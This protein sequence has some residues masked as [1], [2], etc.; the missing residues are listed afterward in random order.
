MTEMIPMQTEF[1]PVLPVVLN[2]VDYAIFRETLLRM[3]EIIVSGELD[4]VVMAYAVS[5]AERE[6]MALAAEKG[7]ALAGLS[8][9]DVIRIQKAGEQALRCSVARHLTGEAYRPFSNRL[10]DSPLLQ[11][12][13]LIDRLD[14]I[15]VPTK[16][17]LQRFEKMVPESMIREIVNK[18]TLLG[19]SGVSPTM[20]HVMGLEDPL[21]LD[22]LYLD[23]TAVKMNIHYPVD[24]VLLRDATRTLMKAVK[25]IRE[26]GLRNRMQEPAEFI[27]G[28]NRLCIEMTQAARKKE[29]KRNRKRIFR[30]M[31]KLVKKVR[32]HAE[33]HLALL[34]EHGDETDLSQ[35]R[36]LAIEKRI[37]GI[38]QKL[39]AAVHQ[40]HERIIG[41]RTVENADKRLSL[42]EDNVHV[43]VRKKA[44]AEVEFGNTLL[45]GEQ[46][47][48][49]IIDWR[50]YKDVAPSDERLLKESLQRLKNDMGVKPKTATTDRGFYSEANRRYLESENIEDY[51]APRSVQDLTQRLEDDNFRI[52][53]RRRAQTEG[54]IGILKNNFLGKTVRS[55]G[56]PSQNIDV[57]W[58]ILAHNLW[59]IAR[60]PK[61]E[62]QRLKQAA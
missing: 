45:L 17:T 9:R 22:D 21:S 58:A 8:E 3:E 29:A 62:E 47:D 16:S 26:A 41:E 15:Q 14:V 2:N 56:F 57:A 60:L 34:R 7:E 13:C 32:R 36:R 38:L 28:I 10:A 55:K 51:M 33:K 30:L 37:E 61:A 27:T 53:Q 1:R 46:A 49:L 11:H 42:Y 35:G 44:G 40:A 48:G 18:L 19:N 20:A 23:T 31:K 24:W 12:F 59:V 6:A 43:L 5:A 4:K 52:H 25:L 54:R 39:P 50:L